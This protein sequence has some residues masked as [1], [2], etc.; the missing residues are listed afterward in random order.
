MDQLILKNYNIFSNIKPEYNKMGKIEIFENELRKMPKSSN[1]FKGYQK[2]TMEN[3]SE[4]K[5]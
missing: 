3:K 2:E 4:M 5:S 1:F